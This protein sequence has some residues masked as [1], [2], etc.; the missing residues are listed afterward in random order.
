MRRTN[1][2]GNGTLIIFKSTGCFFGVFGLVVASLISQVN[3]EIVLALYERIYIEIGE[4]QKKLL[5]EL[6]EADT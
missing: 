5:Q 3:K 4:Q 6:T 2:I 1:V